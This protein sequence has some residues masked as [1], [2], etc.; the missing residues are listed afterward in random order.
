MK[1][2]HSSDTRLL[3]KGTTPRFQI[4]NVN[5]E[6]DI[7]KSQTTITNS[8][9]DVYESDFGTMAVKYDRW[10][11]LGAAAILEEGKFNTAFLRPINATKLAKVGSSENFMVE[12]EFTLESLSENANAVV[13]GAA[14]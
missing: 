12:G 1:K 4:D 9:H 11:P 3:L 13:L 2:H 14:L 10:T 8:S 7:V 5:K 6:D